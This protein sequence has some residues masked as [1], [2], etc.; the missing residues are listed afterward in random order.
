MK[1]RK[2]IIL[3]SFA[4][5]FFLI[6]MTPTWLCQMQ[7]QSIL[8]DFHIESYKEQSKSIEQSH[9]TIEEKL[10]LISK[11]N[12]DDQVVS[13]LHKENL[14][15]EKKYE[16]D[17][18]LLQELHQL[19]SIQIIQLESLPQHLNYINYITQVYSDLTNVNRYVSLW[20]IVFYINNDYYEIWMDADTHKIYQ[21]FFHNENFHITKET[22]YD[23]IERFCIKYL[24]LK[25]INKYYQDSCYLAVKEY[26][27][28][29]TFRIIIE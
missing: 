19:K 29:K 26:K 27:N 5:L 23:I 9:L 1:Y 6:I 4:C 7:E 21:M 15:D 10:E 13:S 24:G 28:D 25:E 14:N 22:S 12:Q 16:L 20:N 8:N 3:L 17:E 2:L 11:Y 18:I